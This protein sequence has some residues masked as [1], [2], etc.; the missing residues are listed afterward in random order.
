[1]EIKDLLPIGTVVTLKEGKKRV[2]IYGVKQT[3]KNT[4]TEYDY[5]AVLYPEGNL[6]EIGSFLFNHSDVEE[7]H[8][9][10]FDDD[11]RTDFLKKLEGFYE[12]TK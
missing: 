11:E 5:I 6:G 9:K 3:D 2:M 1:M 12:K 10:G 8:F 4:G 7:I